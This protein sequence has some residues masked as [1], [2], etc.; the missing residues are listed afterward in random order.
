MY[1]FIKGE[2]QNKRFVHNLPTALEGLHKVS[3][4]DYNIQAKFK[5]P[6]YLSLDICGLSIV[7]DQ[8]A[9]LLRRLD[10]KS[11]ECNHPLVVEIVP[12]TFSKL[13]FS[14]LNSDLEY[15]DGVKFSLTLW[16]TNT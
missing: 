13:E 3:L 16:L 8:Y 14:F 5:N 6:L 15:V 12:K 2:I 11:A 9:S 4:L 10:S 7:H 1:I